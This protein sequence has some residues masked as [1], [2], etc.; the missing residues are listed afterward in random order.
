MNR[1]AAA[2]LCAVA[3]VASPARAEEGWPRIG[4]HLGIALPIVSFGQGVS[5]IGR[6]TLN[7]GLTPGITVKLDERWSIDFEFI[8]FND[9]R[10]GGVTTFVVDPGVLY[11][12]GPVTAG[13]RV[14]TV[15]GNNVNVGL[16]P[17]VV[18]PFRINERFS[19]F[20]ELDVPV[21]FRATGASVA[22]QLQT[23][24]AF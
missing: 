10:T 23:G 11:N 20:I 15:V 16:V 19:Y 7:I 24:V 2:L 12:F 6:D 8:A 4:G 9:F 22:L 5:L 3:V 18:K 21:F 13:L 17:I 1:S 14:A